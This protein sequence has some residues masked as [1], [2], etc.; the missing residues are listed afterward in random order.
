MLIDIALPAIEPNLFIHA[1]HAGEHPL[2]DHLL[3]QCLQTSIRIHLLATLR[4]LHILP[5]ELKS[6]AQKIA[7]LGI[8]YKQEQKRLQRFMA[9]APGRGLWRK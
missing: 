3:E 4:D 2:S 6:I 7:I 9:S 8:S 5:T 1:L